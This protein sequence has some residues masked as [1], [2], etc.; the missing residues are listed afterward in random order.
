MR[1][2]G[3]G[4]RNRTARQLALEML[5]YEAIA[6]KNDRVSDNHGKNLEI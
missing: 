1:N 2:I 5:P 3:Y 6:A 4:A